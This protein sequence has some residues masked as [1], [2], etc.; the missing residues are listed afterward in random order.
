[1]APHG[2]PVPSRNAC[3]T[4]SFEIRRSLFGS[5]RFREM[6]LTADLF[7]HPRSRERSRVL[8]IPS[9]QELPIRSFSE[10]KNVFPGFHNTN[11]NVDVLI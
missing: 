2:W 4:D 6:I 10:K 8:S 1:M 9:R 7:R 3:K 5:T 11:V